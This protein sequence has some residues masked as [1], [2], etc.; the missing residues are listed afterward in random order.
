MT[1]VACFP[2][3]SIGICESASV[4]T[5]DWSIDMRA[6]CQSALE[7][8]ANIIYIYIYIHIYIYIY[9]YIIMPISSVV[10][11]G[12]PGL[13]LPQDHSGMAA[14]PRESVCRR[15]PMRKDSGKHQDISRHAGL[16][17][18]IHD[19]YC[20]ISPENVPKSTARQ[21]LSYNFIVWHVFKFTLFM[22]SMILR[23]FC[24]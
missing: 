22:S 2:P 21:F 19:Q 16:T 13:M 17:I 15:L 1:C 9:I 7:L 8:K 20:M 5:L 10:L 14:R 23:S 4:Q 11:P 18:T 3:S 24:R 6:D 12:F